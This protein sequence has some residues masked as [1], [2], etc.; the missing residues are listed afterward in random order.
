MFAFFCPA[1]HFA[2]WFKVGNGGWTWNG[3]REKPTISPS[4]LARGKRTVT[5]TEADRIM[6]GEKVVIPE[7]RCH[8]F[9]KEGKIQ[10]LGDCTH[11]MKNQTVDL[12]EFLETEAGD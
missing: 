5:D 4:I 11:D 10:F 8:S 1:C 9:V 2:H 12:P 3:N 6:A 7:F